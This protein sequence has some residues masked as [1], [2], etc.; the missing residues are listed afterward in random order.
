[1]LISERQR[2]ANRR[3]AQ[4]STGPKTEDGK[5]TSSLNALKHGLLSKKRFLP[6][7]EKD[8]WLRLRQGVADEFNPQNAYQAHLVPDFQI[9]KRGEK[10]VLQQK[11]KMYEYKPRSEQPPRYLY[12][13]N[14]ISLKGLAPGEYELTLIL[15]DE[16]AK[17]PPAKQ[18]VRFR[19]IPA[20]LPQE[21]E[22]ASRPG[23]QPA[24]P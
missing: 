1:M 23:D 2:E 11:L 19:V 5:A 13:K 8:E 6:G 7:E 12:M 21:Q 3:N 20:D 10:A 14:A 15:H 16:I 9:R 4:A 18:V 17:G 24:S 22:K